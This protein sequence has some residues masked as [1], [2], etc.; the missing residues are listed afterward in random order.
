MLVFSAPAFLIVGALLT[1][2][3]VALHMLA[4]TPPERRPLPT[5]RFLT[6]DRRTRLRLRPPADRVLLALRVLFLLLLAAAFAQPEWRPERAGSAVVVL[7]DAGSAMTGDWENAVAAAAARVADG[8]SIVVFDTTARIYPQPDAATLDSIRTAGPTA[9]PT[10]YVAALRGLRAAAAALPAE[11]A[12][13]VLVTRPRWDAWSPALPFLRETAW[14]AAIE[15]VA[16]G[17]PAS[18][19]DGSRAG[20]G[21]RDTRS[22][23]RAEIV[24][25]E[26][27]PLRPFVAAALRSLDYELDAGTSANVVTVVLPGADPA[28]ARDGATGGTVRFGGSGM[29]AGAGAER[30]PALDRGRLVLPSGHTVGGWREAGSPAGR[31][32]IAVWEDGR[33]AATVDHEAGCTA[34]LAAEPATPAGA[35]DPAFPRLLDT[36]IRACD[37]DGGPVEA[38]PSAVDPLADVPLDAGALAVLRGETLSGGEAPGVDVASLGGVRGHELWRAALLLAVLVAL[39]EA[40]VAYVGRRSG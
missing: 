27:H 6:V 14:P 3:P 5:A 8:G 37:R 18:G 13:A 29:G 11:S 34:H 28:G 22:S 31:N 23:G 40:A 19:P 26:G 35:A 1:T 36:L 32:V 16:A 15:L 9:A 33:P 39:C 2:V 25:A 12:S 21:E 4:R 38:A 24:A 20:A 30:H 7:L 17:S 10:R